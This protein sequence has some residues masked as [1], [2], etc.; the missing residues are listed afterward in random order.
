MIAGGIAGQKADLH[1]D[2]DLIYVGLGKFL[3]VCPPHDI[4]E[5]YEHDGK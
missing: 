4:G 5:I 2:N 3:E 1:F